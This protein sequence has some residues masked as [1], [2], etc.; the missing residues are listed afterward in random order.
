MISR[1]FFLL[2]IVFVLSGLIEPSGFILAVICLL[3][4]IATKPEKNSEGFVGALIR[5]LG[6]IEC[7]LCKETIKKG[8]VKCKHCGELFNQKQPI[9][10]TPVKAK[11]SPI[12]SICGDPVVSGIDTCYA[13]RVK[14]TQ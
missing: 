1:L 7:P 9:N 3:I 12:C 6:E 11:N 14:T 8:A 5:E 13:C 2:A 4:S 10:I